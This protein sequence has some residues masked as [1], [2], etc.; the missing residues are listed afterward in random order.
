MNPQ[1]VAAAAIFNERGEVLLAL[2]PAHLHQGG[3]WEFPGGKL[4]PGE[5]VVAALARELYE[6]LG[7]SVTRARPL[8]RIR[9]AYPDKAVV[10]D[11]WRVDA[12]SG[13]PSPREGQR[14]QWVAINDLAQHAYPEANLPILTALR[15]PSVYLIS[16]EPAQ[17]DA[18]FMQTLR[19]CLHAGIK[20]IQLRAKTLSDDH[21][22]RLAEQALAVCQSHGAQ[23]VLNSTPELVQRLGAQGLHL[24]SERLMKLS[25]RPLANDIWVAASC[26]N[27]AELAHAERIGVDFVVVSPVL[28]TPSHPGAVSLGWEGLKHLTEQA[29]IPV[30]ALGGMESRH[31]LTAYQH[32]AQGIASLRAIWDA[33]QPA[34]ALA[35]FA[36]R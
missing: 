20:L 26:H 31:L 16:S 22:R 30:Y 32:G 2:R 7:I 18:L 36:Q 27:A 8:I 13:E 5:Q 35:E 29:T 23:L 17:G 9:H 14:L 33:A 34:R 6:E 15:L 12:F 11:V 10:L 28:P 19:S 21:Y 1:Q 25:T 3:L 24:T 4:E